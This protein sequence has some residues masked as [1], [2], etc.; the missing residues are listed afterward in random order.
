MRNGKLPKGEPI[1]SNNQK[2]K[3]M[4]WTLFE[5]IKICFN[6][7]SRCLFS[8]FTLR[9]RSFLALLYKYNILPKSVECFKTTCF[10]LNESCWC[11]L[12]CLYFYKLMASLMAVIC[13]WLEHSKSTKFC[14]YSWVPVWC[15]ITTLPNCSNIPRQDM[16]SGSKYRKLDCFLL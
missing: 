3:V 12:S 4:P 14:V 5:T 6:L 11:C 9:K 13:Y 15:N 1:K 16:P 7:F 2:N 10:Q 8:Y